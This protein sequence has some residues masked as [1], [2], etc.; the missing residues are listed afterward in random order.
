MIN[1][2]ARQLWHARVNG[3]R[4]EIEQNQL[5]LD[6]AYDVQDAI[7]ELSGQTQRGWKVGST[8]AAAQAK[9]GTSE[10]GAGPLLADYCYDDN[11]QIAIFSQ[12]EV[13]IE[14]EFAF[15]LGRS[16]Q[17]NA[18]AQ[19]DHRQLA[20]SIEA[21]IP[22]IEIVGSRLKN[23]IDGS[24][25]SLVTADGGAN[26]AFIGGAPRAQWDPLTLAQHPVIARVNETE[27][28]RGVGADALGHPLNV[29]QW[30]TQHCAR[31]G[32]SLT[33]G[34]IVSTGTCS[35]LIE[36]KPGDTIEADFGELGR[37]RAKL[38]DANA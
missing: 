1:E 36:V 26:I 27:L 8:S 4:V 32:R 22:A 5:S 12:H 37:V 16:I 35:G 20:Q 11:A 10:P 6:Q 38:V 23:G 34:T 33:A 24:G 2:V 17:C 9:L 14:A 28:A 30:L 18:D 15:L 19:P 29:L 31:R 25:R 13:H 21:F 3:L 7:V